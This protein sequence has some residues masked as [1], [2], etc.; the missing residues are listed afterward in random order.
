MKN[1]QAAIR[2]SQ[3]KFSATNW[4]QKFKCCRIK[5]WLLSDKS[6]IHFF[7]VVIHIHNRNQRLWWEQNHFK[8]H[9]SYS[10]AIRLP[11]P[12]RSMHFRWRRRDERREGKLAQTTWPETHRPRGNEC[13]NRI[14]FLNF[15]FK[16]IRKL[17]SL[18]VMLHVFSTTIFSATQRCNIVAPLLRHCFE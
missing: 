2:S 9:F 3:E 12:S 8:P 13:T 15:H 7:K 5:R 11:R 10:V 6:I 17:L 18:K 16:V 1:G 14:F 4:M